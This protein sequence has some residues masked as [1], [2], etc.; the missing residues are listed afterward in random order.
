[1]NCLRMFVRIA[2]GRRGSNQKN[3]VGLRMRHMR[4]RTG[5]RGQAHN[6]HQVQRKGEAEESEETAGVRG[7]FQRQR[8]EREL[9]GRKGTS[10]AAR[11]RIR[12][13]AV[14]TRRDIAHGRR[15]GRQAADH[16]GRVGAPARTPRGTR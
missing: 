6:R 12:I 3:G 10:E 11:I 16:S 13:C 7:E 8:R 4:A 15:G 2:V 14:E 1:M 5:D 9:R